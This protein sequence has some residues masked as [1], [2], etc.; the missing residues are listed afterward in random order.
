[1]SQKLHYMEDFYAGQKFSSGSVKVTAEDIVAYA[2][3]FDPQDFHLDDAKAKETVFGGLVASGWHT[4][5]LTMRLML[6]A[7]PPIKGGMIGRHIEKINW[8]RPV[9]PGD[10]LSLES[11]ILEIRPSSTPGRGVARVKHTTFNQNREPVLEMVTVILLPSKT[12]A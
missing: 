2:R 5:S 8:P 1:M 12:A 3:Q 7:S 10:T 11:E 9:K 6:Q 4:A